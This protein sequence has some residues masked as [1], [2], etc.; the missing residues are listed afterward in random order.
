MAMMGAIVKFSHVDLNNVLVPKSSKRFKSLLRL[1]VETKSESG[2][3]IN[4]E[5]N[6]WFGLSLVENASTISTI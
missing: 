3:S 5:I 2:G 4:E 6:L 1:P